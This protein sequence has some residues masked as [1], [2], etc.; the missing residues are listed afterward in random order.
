M[1][2]LDL[3]LAV[4]DLVPV[5]VE[6]VH[7]CS[8]LVFLLLLFRCFLRL[9]HNLCFFF[10]FL[11]FRLLLLL[12]LLLFLFLCFCCSGCLVATGCSCVFLLSLLPVVLVAFLLSAS[13]LLFA[14]AFL[15]V[16]LAYFALVQLVFPPVFLPASLHLFLFLFCYFFLLRFYFLLR[17]YRCLFTSG[18]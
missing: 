14:L 17:L 11:R 13:L 12:F 2:L 18:K 15:S 1:V 3:A 16:R 9:I 4:L 10:Y 6:L 7:Y 8:L 5:L